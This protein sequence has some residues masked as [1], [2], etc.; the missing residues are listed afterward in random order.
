MELKRICQKINCWDE[1]VTAQQKKDLYSQTIVPDAFPDALAV[2]ESCAVVQ[3][4]TKQV[5]QGRVDLSG[6]VL[7]VTTYSA[8]EAGVWSVKTSMPFTARF[9]DERIEPSDTAILKIRP[10]RVAAKVINSRKIGTEALLAIA[11][12]V[13][14]KTEK[15][16]CCAIEDEERYGVLTR[17]RTVKQNFVC[18]AAQKSFEIKDT[19]DLGVNSAGAQE[20]INTEFSLE[21]GDSKVVGSKMILKG[22]LSVDCRYKTYEGTVQSCRAQLPFSQI[23]DIECAEDCRSDISF[24]FEDVDIECSNDG[25]YEGKAL[26][27]TA[28]ITVQAVCRC[29]GEIECIEDIYSTVF[30][31]DSGF[32]SVGEATTLAFARIDEAKPIDRKTMPTFVM[33]PLA[34]GEELWDAAKRWHTTVDA[35]CSAN[36]I[37]DGKAPA[38]KLLLIPV[39]G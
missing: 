19:V 3:V 5:L 36:G 23:L 32:E 31:L 25:Y 39:M 1:I 33:R 20:L 2:G 4:K 22:I 10:E 6:E 26:S 14:R 12:E 7:A 35:I 24:Y 38:G 34:E 11:L 13:Y 37:T 9:D 16:I 27:L 21:T 28:N 30:E 17:K 8:Q 29:T 18:S 15:E